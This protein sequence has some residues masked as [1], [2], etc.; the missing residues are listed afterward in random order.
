ML[1]KAQNKAK[2]NQLKKRMKQSGYASQWFNKKQALADLNSPEAR[3]EAKRMN[4]VHLKKLNTNPKEL[5][6]PTVT[7]N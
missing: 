3:Q 6:N 2:V 5:F 1:T 7:A 4:V